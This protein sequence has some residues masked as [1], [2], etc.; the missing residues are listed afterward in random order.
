MGFSRHAPGSAHPTI[1]SAYSAEVLYTATAC[2]SP[3][4]ATSP[5]SRQ[6]V[7]AHEICGCRNGL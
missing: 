3:F 4:S 1:H 6:I 7:V 2:I 5:I